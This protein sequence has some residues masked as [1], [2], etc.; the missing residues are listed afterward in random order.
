MASFKFDLC[1]L[2]VRGIHSDEMKRRSIFNWL[3]VHNNG[4]RSIAFLQETHSSVKCENTWRSEWGSDIYYSHGTTESRG[5][6]ILFP[7]HLDITV[8]QQLADD[9]GRYVLLDCIIEGSRFIFVNIYAP[10]KNHVAEQCEFLANLKQTMEPFSGENVLVGGDF[11]TV[12]DPTI[13]KKGGRQEPISQYMIDLTELIEDYQLV[14]IW[15]Q[16]NPKSELFTFHTRGGELIQS[17]LDFWLLSGFLSPFVKHCEI[18]PSIK[19]DHSMIT[20]Q[21]E[22]ELWNKRGSGFWKFNSSLLHDQHYVDL[23]KLILHESL[24]RHNNLEDKGLLWDTIKCE[25]RGMTITFSKR[26]SFIEKQNMMELK[27]KYDKLS[28]D[29]NSGNASDQTQ[30]DLDEVVK[31]LETIN[32]KQTRSTMLRSKAKWSELGEK[33]SAYFLGLEK[34][35][36]KNKCITTLQLDDGTTTT[37]PNNILEAEKVFYKNL[38]TS[39]AELTA[40][41]EFTD[42]AAIP[43]LSQAEQVACEG[44]VSECECL[45]ALKQF[46]NNKSPGTDG[47]TA[48]FYKFFWKDIKTVLLDSINYSFSS[49]KLSIDQRRGIIT[50][51][52]KKDKDRTFL[53]NWRPI[54]LLNTDYKLIAKILALRLRPALPNII[55]PDQTGYVKD[56]FIGENILLIT[57]ILFLTKLR[58]TPGLLLL[59]DFKKAFDSIEWDFLRKALQS[60]NFGPEFQQWIKVLYTD[61]SSCVT[62]NGSA[63]AFFT[64]T[65]SVRQGCPLAPYLFIIAVELL[66]ISIRTNDNIKGIDL[67]GISCKISQ[68]ADDT[69][70]FVSDI[71]S[72]KELFNLLD[73]FGKCSGLQCNRDK[74]IARWLGRNSGRPPEDLPVSWTTDEFYTLGITF[75][76]D[77][78]AME[79]KNYSSKIDSLKGLL[80][81]WRMRDLSAIGKITI[82]KALGISKLTYVASMVY[83]SPETSTQVQSILNKFVWNHKPPKVKFDTLISSISEGGLKMVHFESQVK[84]LLLSWVRRL[85]FGGNAHWKETF[86]LYFADFEVCDFLQSRCV[87]NDIDAM[88]LPHIYKA[89]VRYWREFRSLFKPVSSVDVRK[90]FL[91]FNDHITIDRNS[92]FLKTWYRCGIKYISDIIDQEGAFLSAEQLQHKFGLRT[93]FLELYQIRMAIPHSWRMLLNEIP[94]RDQVTTLEFN[95]CNGITKT[96]NNMLCKDFYWVFIRNKKGSPYTP[97]AVSRWSEHFHQSP[98]DWSLI[99]GLS[100]NCTHES[101]LQAFQYKI[102]HRIV[103]HKSLLF[104]QNIVSEETCDFCDR[105]D[106]VIHRFWE[107]N[108]ITIFWHELEQ[109][110]NNLQAYTILTV[111]DE[112]ILFGIFDAGESP[113]LYALNNIILNAKLFIHKIVSHKKQVLFHPFKKYFKDIVLLEKE[114]FVRKAKM[115]VFEA[116]W[117]IVLENL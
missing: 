16:R 68:L 114:V 59:I 57:D 94:V 85:L 93:H 84:S 48:E 17:R 96:L 23:V 111:S 30:S 71:Q 7:G 9:N 61:I 106:T 38:Y 52:P 20:M 31:E 101:K 88:Q 100:F 10:T 90:E 55:N 91:W 102:L 35:N 73:R 99:F 26:K 58:N 22:G 3:Q 8:S 86:N 83:T 117:K 24:E 62:N 43:K 14:D 80:R 82:L 5:V 64:L 4:S 78:K 87:Y 34:R 47:F 65:R 112:K 42:N 104:R 19:T 6:A 12:L 74:T 37:V 45:A 41:T 54:T 32:D 11:N 49:G 27:R 44:I 46:K 107:C 109:W 15:R 76:D 56:R 108:N 79:D 29:L 116:R 39:A 50:L 67:G 103:P 28:A 60:F 53:K 1:S 77:L 51:I 40:T 72:A 63:S 75:L 115:N 95:L 98:L 66:A 89:I 25:I 33:S 97:T 70:C 18:R 69:S 13:D 36:Y 21:L 110:W 2:N 81:I 113:E 105:V 92:V